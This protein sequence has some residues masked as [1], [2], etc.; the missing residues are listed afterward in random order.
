MLGRE[1]RGTPLG[2]EMA[3]GVTVRVSAGAGDII[4]GT[5]FFVVIGSVG[6][7][8]AGWLW[9]VTVGVS[10]VGVAAD[11]AGVVGTGVDG[12]G[13]ELKESLRA[14]ESGDGGGG[15]LVCRA[16]CSVCS[17]RN[18]FSR[19]EYI[20]SVEVAFTFCFAY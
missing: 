4:V 20:F 15:S 13:S 3:G 8:V 11:C 14:V 9:I 6:S 12:G 5:T 1:R 10:M 18:S 2:E 7:A 16:A 17:L 19:V